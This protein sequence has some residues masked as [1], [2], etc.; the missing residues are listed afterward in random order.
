MQELICWSYSDSTGW[1]GIL[2]FADLIIEACS[3]RLCEVMEDTIAPV[4]FKK[5]FNE[6]NVIQLSLPS[7]ATTE[8]YIVRSEDLVSLS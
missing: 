6:L 2:S 3:Y 4:F 7:K 8:A 5:G 1:I